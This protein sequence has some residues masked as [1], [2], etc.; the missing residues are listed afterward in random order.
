M[1]PILKQHKILSC[2]YHFCHRSDTKKS[3]CLIGS[4]TLSSGAMFAKCTAKFL[5]YSL[6]LPP[7]KAGNSYHNTCGLYLNHCLYENRW[8][9]A[10]GPPKYSTPWLVWTPINFCAQARSKIVTPHRNFV[11]PQYRLYT[12]LS[13]EAYAENLA[14]IASELR[15]LQPVKWGKFF[16][17]NPDRKLSRTW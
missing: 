16:V 1:K 12:D 15:V 6:F 2:T 13:K 9:G 17:P 14:K 8:V 3:P 10:A 11:L 7:A 5:L 4:K